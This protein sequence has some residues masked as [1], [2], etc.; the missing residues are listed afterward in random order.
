[1]HSII[2]K[3]TLTAVLFFSVHLVFSQVHDVITV[4]EAVKMAAENNLTVRSEKYQLSAKRRSSRNRWNSFVPDITAGSA[5]SRANEKP[6]IGD[7]HW[8]LSSSI[9]AQLA[10]SLSL[11]DGIKYLMLDY[12]AGQISYEDALKAL[13]RDVRKSFYN[14]ILLRENISLLEE[15]M[16]T[17]EKR[18][19]QADINFRNGLVSELDKLQSRVSYEQLKPEYVELKNSYAKALLS[20]KQI[21]GLE[22]E[23]DITLEGEI[24]PEDYVIE[25]NELIFTSLP[26]RL[27]IQKLIANIKLMKTSRDSVLHQDKFPSLLFTYQ[28]NMVFLNDPLA[29]PLFKD[30]ENDWTDAGAFTISLSFDLDSYIPGFKTDTELK[31]REDEIKSLEAQL[32]RTLQLAETEI[33]SYVM[34]I[35]KSRKKIEF[36]LM[37]EK[38]SERAYEQAEEGYNAGTVELLTLESSSDDLQKARLNVLSEKYNYQAALLDLEYAINKSLEDVYEEKK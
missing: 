18:Y 30:T 36:L 15:N 10:L 17:A 32:A 7:Y 1:M 28:K 11:F 19:N 26:N 20:F 8:N 12:E 14:I 4:D 35:E 2:K 23:A 5:Y 31:N 9:Q 33:R 24:A 13:E 34:E 16:K 38:L 25:V 6:V 22:K 37:N 29:D 3:Q 27:D 21:I